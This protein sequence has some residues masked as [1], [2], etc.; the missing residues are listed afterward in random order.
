MRVQESEI[1]NSELIIKLGTLDISVCELSGDDTLV[2]EV[3]ASNGSIYLGGADFDLALVEHFI[4]EFNKQNAGLLNGYD[5]R[6][7]T[8]AY[9]RLMEAAEKAKCELS[10]STTTEINL[11]YLTALSG[12]PV[13][14]TLTVTRAKYEQ[15]TKHIV[16]KAINITSKAFELADKRPDEIDEILLVG[17]MTRSLNIQEALT[18]TF[19]RP[20][21]KSINPDEAVSLGAAIQANILAGGD[22][23]KDIL[24]LDVTPL[25]LGLNTQGDVMTKLIPANTTIPTR[26]TEIF[27]TA[28]DNQTAVTIQVLQGE[29]PMAY[30]NKSI[31]MFNLEGIA[32]AKRGVPQIEVTFDIDANGI[33]SV[34]AKDLGTNKEQKITIDNNNSLDQ[35]E[36]D[37][38]KAE[39]EK[40][41]EED[42]K[43]RAL[44]AKANSAESF[45]YHVQSSMEE[46]KFAAEINDELKEQLN[47]KINELLDAAKAKE[48]EKI[49][50]LQKELSDLFNPI[51]QKV[52]ASAQPAE[53]AAGAGGMDF[54][55]MMKQAQASGGASP[56]SGAGATPN[57]TETDT[58]TAEF[59]EVK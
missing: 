7:D 44:V 37:R 50:S 5:L 1:K 51:A 27:S 17:G 8:Q 52:Y 25:S 31:G 23:A 54:E 47:N 35:E 4:E 40:Y 18:K 20:L 38:I 33:L 41:K 15:L 55:E 39:A 9:S 6:K 53:G 34:S 32:P 24:L 43:Q 12:Q 2:V 58:D 10:S 57:N 3:L 42:E 28:V 16:D 46:E 19:G 26:K 49:D 11:P 22:N 29:R 14:F 48:E 21:N 13:H 56:F 36:I 59:E 30:Q 45:A